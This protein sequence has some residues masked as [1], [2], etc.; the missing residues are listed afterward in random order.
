MAFEKDFENIFADDLKD[1]KKAGQ[2]YSALANNRWQ[3]DDQIASYSWRAA[4]GLVADT[5]NRLDLEIANPEICQLC[6]QN[7]KDHLLEERKAKP[8]LSDEEI[9]LIYYYCSDGSNN[10][11]TPGYLGPEDYMDFYCFGGEG[12]VLGWVEEKFSQAGYKKLTD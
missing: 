2:I 9:S 3:K 11:F 6:G 8:F 12:T 5:R 1:T 4:A 10:Q 7:K